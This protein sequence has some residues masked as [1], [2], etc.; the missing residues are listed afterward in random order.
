MPM[1]S[2]HYGHGYRFGF[3]GKEQD[4]EVEGVGNSIDYGARIYDSRL[5]R[6]LS[7]DPISKKF[8]MLTP[9]Q[10]ASNS[11][12]QAIDLDGKEAKYVREVFSDGSTVITITVDAKIRDLTGKL[13]NEEV[14]NFAIKTQNTTEGAYS[15][16]DTKN[17][18]TYNLVFRKITIDNNADPSKEWVISLEDW[19][20]DNPTLGQTETIGDTKKNNFRIDI[21]HPSA[22]HTTAHELGHGMGLHH[23]VARDAK[24]GLKEGDAK[25]ETKVTD[26]PNNLMREKGNNG[27]DITFEQLNTVIK[28]IDKDGGG[29]TIFHE[30][31]RPV[32]GGGQVPL[33]E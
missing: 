27:T 8:P 29:T 3:N 17:N 4:N 10:F 16:T 15:K 26:S 12:I 18:I 11:S 2:R 31:A 5:G 23:P 25:S 28:T 9:Y 32:G 13:T 21:S 7:V 30:Q 33:K 14:N 19:G 1:P 6:F 20:G 22:H 24:G